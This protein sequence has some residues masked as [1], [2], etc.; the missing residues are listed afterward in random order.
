MDIEELLQPLLTGNLSPPTPFP[1]SPPLT[2]SSGQLMDGMTSNDHPDMDSNAEFG[3]TEA[4]ARLE[5]SLL[6]KVDARMSI[7]I[8]IYIL[9]CARSVL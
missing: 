7:L 8:L 1:S 4:R 9:N 5:S 2:Y 3:G 6:K